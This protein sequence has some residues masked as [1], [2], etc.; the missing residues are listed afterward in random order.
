MRLSE[1]RLT[2]NIT[3]DTNIRTSVGG[4]GSRIVEQDLKQ[5]GHGP[6]LE[7]THVQAKCG[8]GKK[9][10]G[11]SRSILSLQNRLTTHVTAPEV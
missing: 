8:D 9:K 10:S 2:R 11:P 6:D 1:N 7:E 3:Q 5:A 4:T